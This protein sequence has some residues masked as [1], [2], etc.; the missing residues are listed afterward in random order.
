VLATGANYRASLRPPPFSSVG[1]HGSNYGHQLNDEEIV[2]EEVTL[3]SRGQGGVVR[4]VSKANNNEFHELTDTNT[5]KG[6][7]Q[8]EK[9]ILI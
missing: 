9:V 4:A 7:H 8:K 5:T 6:L 2:I 3:P 1:H